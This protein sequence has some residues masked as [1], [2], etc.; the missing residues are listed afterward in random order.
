[1]YR[2]VVLLTIITLSF[3]SIFAQSNETIYTAE[4]RSSV[5]APADKISFRISIALNNTDPELLLKQHDE[6]EQ[7]LLA[8]LEQLNIPDSTIKFSLLN[9][10]KA[11]TKKDD[12]RIESR[13]SVIFNITDF[14]KYFDVQIGLLNIG[15]QTFQPVFSTTH[16]EDA[17]KRGVKKALESAQKEAELYAENLNMRVS[18]VIEIE[19][20]V[21]DDFPY[22]GA[23]YLQS[24]TSKKLLDIPQQIN[25]Q[26]SVKVKFALVSNE[27]NHDQMN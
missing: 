9:V 15:I 1:M 23:T 18:R 14:S 12:F 16:I 13:Q 24:G 22:G 7:K 10:R 19:S 8:L 26:S 11:K 25:V 27:Y 2:I 4:V 3:L 20:R 5:Q 21:S 17:K 6:T